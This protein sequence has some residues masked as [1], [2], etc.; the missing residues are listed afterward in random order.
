MNIP[1]ARL[2]VMVGIAKLKRI[3]KRE[4]ERTSL[5][6]AARKLVSQATAPAPRPTIAATTA[7][8]TL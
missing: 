8:A 6:K 2:N 5:V 4:L 1:L 3:S 7:G